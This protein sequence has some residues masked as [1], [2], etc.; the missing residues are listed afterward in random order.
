M[1]AVN[2]L[3]ACQ[4]PCEKALQRM[5]LR[6]WANQDQF[7]INSRDFMQNP[8]STTLTSEHF[9]NVSELKN[10]FAQRVKD[11]VEAR[12]NIGQRV[13]ILE[14]LDANFV[15]AYGSYFFMNP[16]FFTKQGRNTVWDMRDI[17]EGFS[18]NPPLPSLENPDKCFVLKYREMR[19]FGPD[20]D[21]WRTICA[22][23]GS[24]VSGI[25]FEYKLDSLAAV[26]RECPFWFRD[27]VDNHGGWDAVIL[28]G[29]IDFIDLDILIRDGL[30]GALNGP[31]RICEHHSPLLFEME[32]ATPPLIA[33]TFL[34]KIVAPHYTKLIDYFE[35]VVQRLKRAEGLLSR[36]TDKEDYNS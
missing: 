27:A 35:I 30:N 8:A 36:Q 23:S 20:Y 33:S 15:E 21:H 6:F 5:H 11:D 16:L 10:R 4:L 19:N 28:Y 12:P 22:T 14:R 2:G 13:Y 9:K 29:Y 26:E 1:Y 24:H 3:V 34:E 31:P 17:Q 7:K 18:D 32:G 25:G